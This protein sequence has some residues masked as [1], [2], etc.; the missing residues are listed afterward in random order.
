MLVTTILD[1]TSC[2]KIKGCIINNNKAWIILPLYLASY[3]KGPKNLNALYI[4]TL[5]FCLNLFAITLIQ[6][7]SKFVHVSVML[8]V[9]F[10]LCTNDLA[11]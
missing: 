9:G 2:N 5:E 7:L 10:S 4:R 8:S 1:L 3:I 6:A 11:C